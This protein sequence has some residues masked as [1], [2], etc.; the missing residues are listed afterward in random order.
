MKA[1]FKNKI[2]SRVS[3]SLVAA[4]VAVLASGMVAAQEKTSLRVSVIPIVDVAPLYAAIKQGYF[5]EQGLEVDPSPV[6]GGAAGIPGLIG[7]AYDIVF[8]NVVSAVLASTQGIDLKMIAPGSRAGTDDPDLAAIMVRKDS[9]ISSAGDLSGKS[10]AVNTKNNVIWLFA[11]EW[12]DQ[13]G[14]DANRVTYR[15]VPFPQ[16][17]DALKGRQVDSVFVV[18]PFYAFGR[19][20]PDIEFLSHPYVDVQPNVDVAQYIALD[21]FIRDNPET[22][23]RFAKAIKKGVQWVND[24]R[25]TPAFGELVGSYSRLSPEMVEQI[26][27]NAAPDSVVVEEVRKTA[28]IMVKQGLLDSVPDVD[29]LIHQSAR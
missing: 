11:R 29:A 15:E 6:A 14:G 16:M 17:I 27:V 10:M 25:G 4:L 3:V 19:N 28:E 1:L 26:V 22:V 20:D 8:T 21:H 9:G 12:V 2:S 7:G 18:E 24:N 5:E 23:E 13:A